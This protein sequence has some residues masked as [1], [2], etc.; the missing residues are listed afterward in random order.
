MRAL[1]RRGFLAL[2]NRVMLTVSGGIS[3]AGLWRFLSYAPPPANP[4]EY[5]LGPANNFPPGSRTTIREA[6]AILLHTSTGFSAL[7]T[8]CP[9]LGCE[10]NEVDQ[11]YHCPCHGSRFSLQG[12][13]LQGPAG[14]PLRQLQVIENDDGHLVLLTH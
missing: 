1:T 9:H 2:A 14:E 8:I 12:E 11:E 13:R 4:R 7:S 3:L 6:R 10:V 5:D